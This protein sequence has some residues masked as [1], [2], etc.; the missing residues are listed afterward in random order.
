MTWKLAVEG[1]LG[2]AALALV[3]G[4]RRISRLWRVVASVEPRRRG[5][6]VPAAQ[7]S[8]EPQQTRSAEEP[9]TDHKPVRGAK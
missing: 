3:L 7:Q 9:A 1:V 5:A 8:S 2:A 4:A 6:D